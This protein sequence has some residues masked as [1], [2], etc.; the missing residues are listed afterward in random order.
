[1]VLA[2]DRAYSRLLRDNDSSDGCRSAHLSLACFTSLSAN[3]A[4]LSRRGC[5]IGGEWYRRDFLRIALSRGQSALRN[6]VRVGNLYR[7]AG[8]VLDRIQNTAL[9]AKI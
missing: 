7:G 4:R 6:L 9:V 2:M 5:R 8:R 3:A 1:M